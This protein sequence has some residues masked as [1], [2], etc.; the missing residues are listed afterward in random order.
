MVYLQR[1]LTNTLKGHIALFAAQ[2]IYALN[3][4]MAKGLMP[5]FISPMAIVFSRIIGAAV[6]FWILSLFVETQK[7]AK[8]DLKRM[9]LLA[10]F[11]VVINQIFFIYGLSITTPINSSII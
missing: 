1:F 4:T 5:T 10:L 3:Y 6:L 9:A 2:I 7:I 8:A 11:G